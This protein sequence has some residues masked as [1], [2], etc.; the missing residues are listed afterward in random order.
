MVLKNKKNLGIYFSFIVE[1]K[2]FGVRYLIFVYNR[3]MWFLIL[4]R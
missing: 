4:Y 3:Y 2:N 1:R